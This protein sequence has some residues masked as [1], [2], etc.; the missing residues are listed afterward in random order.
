[1]RIPLHIYG[2]KHGFYYLETDLL[3]AAAAAQDYWGILPVVTGEISGGQPV[4]VYQEDGS[5]VYA[6][7]V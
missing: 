6:Q 4:F 2:Q 5:L 3:A 1:M 7:V